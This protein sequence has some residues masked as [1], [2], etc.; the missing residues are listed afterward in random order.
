MAT[1]WLLRVKNTYANVIE[2]LLKYNFIFRASLA[3]KCNHS[4]EPNSEFVLSF[5]PRFGKVP[6][7]KT[8]KSVKI[9]E[10]ITVSYDYALDDA[11][12]WYQELY[13]NRILD[14]YAQSKSEEVWI[15]F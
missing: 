12:P 3:H 14:C 6:S 10:E 2:K 11:P 1:C 15:F 8:L 9:G 5:H 4:F 13:A 7:V